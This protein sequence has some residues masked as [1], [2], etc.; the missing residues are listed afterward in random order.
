VNHLGN[1]H[2]G[3]DVSEGNPAI[4]VWK[5]G[6]K[7]LSTFPN[8]TMK[9]SMLPFIVPKNWESSPLVKN[10]VKFVIDLFGTSRCMF[11]SNFP[12]DQFSGSTGPAT[13][14]AFS[15][16]AAEYSKEKQHELFYG[17][18]EKVYRL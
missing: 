3:S 11:A 9:I 8:V 7:L 5:E 18:A 16:Y 2:L 14:K 10:L 12:T 13:Y 6:M 15:E 4:G 1:L 17:T